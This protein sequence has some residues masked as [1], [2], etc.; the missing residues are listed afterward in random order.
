MAQERTFMKI[1]LSDYDNRKDEITRDLMTASTE[2]GFFY[3]VNHGISVQQIRTMF[4][5]SHDFFALP[6]E[7]KAKTPMD[8]TRNAGWEKLAQIRPST[9]VADLK[10]SVQLGW[11]NVD[12]LW[13]TQEDAPG[14]KTQS[15][16]FMEQCQDVSMKILSCLAIGLGFEEDFFLSKHDVTQPDCQQTLRCLHYH[17]ITGKT[18]PPE[19]W[20][21]GAHTDFDTL[22]LL[23][24]KPGENGLEVC[25]GREA[26]TDFAV[27]DAWSPINPGEGEIV[28]NI[29][30]MI[31][32][33]SDDRLK[34][35]FHRVR[36][37]KVGEY[38]G[39]RYSLAYFN[40]ANK[41]AII[42][43]KSKYPEAITAGQFL[44]DAME[45]NYKA[46]QALKAAASA[47]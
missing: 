15:L 18:F 9:G 40:Q 4:Q 11:Q 44:Q 16:H 28:C 25:P 42:Q 21:A 38:Q 46:L 3:V 2:Q 33:W 8:K 47:E 20:R 7:I 13:P 17:D 37:P 1:D 27:G 5:T 14:F 29:G 12:D 6:D 32:R 43:G 45:R 30:D 34:S 31:M 22:T 19:Y 10:E 36:T 41:S 23:F 39:P 35:N 26:S 24:Q